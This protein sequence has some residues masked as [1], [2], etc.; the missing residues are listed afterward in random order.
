MGARKL[1]SG[2]F[3]HR[4]LKKQ[5][6]Q[7]KYNVA[8]RRVRSTSIAVKKTVIITYSEC[9]SA[10]LVNQHAKRVRHVIRGLPDSTAFSHIIS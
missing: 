6:R 5:D 4:L 1:R 7:Y 8:L 2:V 10:A 9:V 3:W